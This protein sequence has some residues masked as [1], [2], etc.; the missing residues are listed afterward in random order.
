MRSSSGSPFGRVEP[1]L[2]NAR[3][4]PE[5]TGVAV[6]QPFLIEKT[7][8]ER[9]PMTLTQGGF[10]LWR[11]SL[12]P[13]APSTQAFEFFEHFHRALSVFVFVSGMNIREAEKLF[14]GRSNNPSATLNIP[15]VEPIPTASDRTATIVNVGFLRNCRSA[16]R[17]LL[18]TLPSRAI[19]NPQANPGF[20][21][22]PGGGLFTYE[23]TRPKYANYLRPFAQPPATIV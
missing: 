21:D 6:L 4:R 2:A 18:I 16:N 10:F 5:M 13:Q 8:P 19:S 7:R 20:S 11:S 3:T 23:E 12:L 1:G 9:A 17:T 15:D 14:N 22:V